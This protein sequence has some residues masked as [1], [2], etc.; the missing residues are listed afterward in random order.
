VV[1]EEIARRAAIAV[2][3]ARLYA[4][5]Q[6]ARAAADDANR[7]KDEFLATVSHE[8]RTPLN[9]I[10]GWAR[11]VTTGALDE[12]RRPH[13]L[14]TI[15]RNAVAMAQLIEDLL[16]VS[17]VISGK[18]RLEVELLE[19]AGVVG[20]AIDSVR[21]AAA[22]KDIT[23]RSVLEPF[24]GT[25]LGDP[26]R[27]QQIVWNLL[28]NAVKFTP[29]G[30]KVEVVVRN[31]AS[32]V[33]LLVN[34]TGAGIDPAFVPFVFDRFRQEDGRSTRVHGGLGLGLAITRHL[35]ELHG[36]TIAAQSDGPGQGTRFTV[37][38][39]VTAV[40]RP[41]ERTPRP[42][43]SPMAAA[44]NR[45]DE[46][47][48]VLQGLRVLAVDDDPDS[49]RLVHAVL[50]MAGAKVTAAT[51]VPDALLAFEQETP[52]VLVSDIGMPEHDGMELMR[53]I[54]AL[55]PEKGGRIPAAALTG[56]ARA[57]DRTQM[58]SAG[59]MIH[60]AKPV[61]PDELLAAV[62]SLARFA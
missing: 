10:L 22:A 8:L 11:M 53:R 56:Y 27:I 55:P 57:A 39:P 49:L 47:L 21:P 15:E 18:M 31:A 3:N 29:R 32:S 23:I 34:D 19:L 38:L 33:E 42:V 37:T 50:E 6:Q 36:G 60:L 20:A 7:L 9:A 61:E 26:G 14:E 28:S 2:D 12:S 62:A 45:V 13:A 25:V 5:E 4:A 58:L 35:V 41:S 17:R 54:R 52:Q 46:R 24:A 44:R 43:P 30:G 1:A 16:D 59:Y 51:N 40:R 48:A